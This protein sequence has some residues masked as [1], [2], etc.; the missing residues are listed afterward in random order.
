MKVVDTLH[1]CSD[2]PAL[3]TSETVAVRDQGY[4]YS[5]NLTSLSSVSI[6]IQDG[7]IPSVLQDNNY[8][9]S[10]ILSVR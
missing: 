8:T 6:I 2:S 5:N 7:F 3:S 10:D 1:K 9:E 4:E